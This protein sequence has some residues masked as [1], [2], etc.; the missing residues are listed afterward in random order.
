[1]EAVPDRDL[2]D[3]RHSDT[4]RRQVLVLERAGRRLLRANFFDSFVFKG[5]RSLVDGSEDCTA[6]LLDETFKNRTRQMLVLGLTF[7]VTIFAVLDN[8]VK[9]TNENHVAASLFNVDQ[10]ALDGVHFR[11]VWANDI[12]VGLALLAVAFFIATRRLPCACGYWGHEAS[13]IHAQQI[14]SLLGEDPSREVLVPQGGSMVTVDD[15]TSV[16]RY[17]PQ[18]R[19]RS[20]SAR[21]QLPTEGPCYHYAHSPR[22]RCRLAPQEPL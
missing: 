20:E 2:Q 8:V 6:D 18:S 16:V 9:G 12:T 5:P 15:A 7:R 11:R 1:M 19:A 17:V 14:S 3:I 22:H 21:L 4:T 13:W 10:H